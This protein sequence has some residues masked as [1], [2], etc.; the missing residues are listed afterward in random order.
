[1]QNFKYRFSSLG[2]SRKLVVIFV[3]ML[4]IPITVSALVSYHYY[5]QSIEQNTAD[6]VSQTSMEVLNKIE[7]YIDYICEFFK[8]GNNLLCA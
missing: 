5:R 4:I 2:M 6:Y 8:F 1:M 3:F 7:D